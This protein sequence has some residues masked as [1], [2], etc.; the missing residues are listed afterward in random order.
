MMHTASW[1]PR[2]EEG[3][4]PTY[5]AIA[6]AVAESIGKGELRAG[7]RLPPQR[8]L[9]A[10]L[11][12]DFTTVSRGYAEA[13]RRGLLEARVG[14]G[15]YVKA[16]KLQPAISHGAS[17]VDMLINH[18]PSF[19]DP[20]LEKRIWEGAPSVLAER[21]M[22]M[23]MRYQVPSGAMRDRLVGAN[24]L[25]RRVPGLGP[26]RVLVCPG[27]QGALL[28][29]SMMLA[30][31]GDTVCVESLTYPG[32][33][34]L[35]KEL[36]IR[37]AAVEMDDQGAR[38]DSLDQICRSDKPKAFYCTPIIHNPTTVNMP[39]ER[40][41]ELVEVARRHQLPIIEDDN[42]WPLIEASGRPGTSLD[43][44]PSLASL[45]PELVY[46]ISGLAKCVSPALRI[47]YLA[48]PDQGSAERASV[49]I[50]A[51]ASMA[52]PLSAAIATY[53][54]ESGLAEDMLHAICAESEARQAIAHRYL[55]PD[56]TNPH[57]HGFHLWLPLPMPWT[58]SAFATQLRLSGI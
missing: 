23:L 37:L 49:V 14:R 8:T 2:L 24:W 21:G 26:E 57:G 4:G 17:T 38:P 43:D 48:V 22:D 10:A 6:N 29:T 47:A 36:G 50:R 58:R 45:A 15:T 39:I 18:P 25:A 9:A 40:R 20:A 35:A 31:A 33:M 55:G 46:Y 7:D 16:V 52:A 41:R 42:Y 11:G 1:K 3:S 54:I 30:R 13:Q 19:D 5:Q 53:W 34:L 12:I 32:Y 28:A 51:T 27:A 44:L 56:L